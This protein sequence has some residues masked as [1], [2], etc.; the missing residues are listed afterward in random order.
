[1]KYRMLGKNGLKVSAIGLGCMGM[2][3]FYGDT[4][5]KESIAVIKRA[6]E[7]SIN[8]F[9]TADGYGYGHNEQLLG[10][11]VKEIRKQVIIATKCG[12]VRK[13]DDP[14]ARGVN[15]TPEYIEASCKSS[16]E[17]LGTDYIDLFYLHRIDRNTPIEVSVAAMAKL[18]KSGAVRYIGLSEANADTIR[19]AHAVHPIT[20]IQTEYSLWTRSPEAEVIQTCRELNIGFV[21]YSPIGRGFLTGKITNVNTLADNDFRKSLP[22]FQGENLQ[23]NLSIVNHLEEMAKKKNCTPAQ[24]SLAWVLAQGEDMVPIPGTKRQRYLEENVVAIDIT[25]T[26]EELEKLNKIAPPGIAVGQRYAP[27]AMEAYGFE[28]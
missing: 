3:E 20:A 7:L 8:F 18:V 11:A 27:A 21:P 5:D 2:S 6:C 26:K 4:N 9:D 23:S 15:G 24:L 14:S 10:N 22:R 28:S 1:M 16:L 13:K 12:I 25:L 17:R 19:R